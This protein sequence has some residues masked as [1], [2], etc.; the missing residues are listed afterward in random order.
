MITIKNF[1]I[2]EGK[3]VGEGWHVYAI[4]EHSMMY[5]FRGKRCINASILQYT[6]ESVSLDRKVIYEDG[7][8]YYS[9]VNLSTD[10]KL[11][12]LRS[13]IEDLLQ[14]QDRLAHVLNYSK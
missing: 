12:I 4:T 9:M 10:K 7:C 1:N 3:D 2:L 5:I 14:F 11:W 6:Y 13:T 8:E